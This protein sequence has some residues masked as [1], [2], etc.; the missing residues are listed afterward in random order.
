V[1]STSGLSF[2]PFALPR[3][4]RQWSGI[5]Y[6]LVFCVLSFTGFEG[7][8]TL[9]EETLNPRRNIPIAI[10]GTCAL[11]GVF[12]VFVTYAQV[13]GFGIAATRDL[14][15]ASAPLNDLAVRYVSRSFAT[16]IDLAAALSALSCTVG[17]LSAAARLLF[18]LDRAGL[19][20]RISDVHPVHGTPGT[21][22]V[23]TTWMCATGLVLWAKRAGPA[24]YAA[25]LITIGTLALIVV[26]LGVNA[27][28]L[29]HAW[30]ARRAARSLC[31]FAGAGVLLWPLYNSLY[32]APAFPNNVWPYVVAGWMIAGA[33]AATWAKARPSKSPTN[34]TEIRSSVNEEI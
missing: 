32:P 8:A 25:Y 2:K 9:G 17:S 31:A 7:A 11:A 27:A 29:A 13:M 22:V 24:N 23:V 18:A 26:Y 33:T 5:G 30:A 16:A 21:A 4:F 12:Y 1:G 6:A 19:R 34:T 3:G 20:S 10:L 15:N 14:A 28:E